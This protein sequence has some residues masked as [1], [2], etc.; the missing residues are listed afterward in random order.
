[1]ESNDSEKEEITKDQHFLIDLKII[2]KLISA[3][4]LKKED[5]II[6]IGAGQ[7]NITQELV[8]IKNPIFALELDEKFKSFLEEISKENKNFQFKIEN[9]LDI[10]WNKHNKII[11]NIPF[12]AAE[13]II[14]KSIEDRIELLSLLISENLK[15]TLS[16]ESKLGLITNLFFE[17]SIIAEVDPQSLS[18]PPSIGCYII[19]LKRKSPK[20]KV[21]SILRDILTK[22]GK[23]KN[24]ILFS[25]AKSGMTK[26]QARDF[27]SSSDLTEAVLDKQIRRASSHLIVRLAEELSKLR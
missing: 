14:Q 17:L 20:N 9:A 23:T 7:G 8:K 16:S 15:E 19:Q 6:E 10:P 26:N 3:I 27:I 13:A 22:N 5:K 21:E 4:D 18:P 12:S 24:A 11:G 1:M 25:L 2:K